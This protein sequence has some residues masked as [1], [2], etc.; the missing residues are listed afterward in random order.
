[1]KE[2]IP[3]TN[4]YIKMFDAINHQGDLNV[5]LKITCCVI[6]VRMAM[7]IMTNSGEIRRET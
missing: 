6:S 5:K 1:M 7:G 3:M 4:K 2:A